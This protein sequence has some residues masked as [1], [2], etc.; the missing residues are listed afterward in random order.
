LALQIHRKEVF[1]FL[2]FFKSPCSDKKT[3][4][5]SEEP[6][7]KSVGEVE[8]GALDLGVR[9]PGLRFFPHNMQTFMR[10]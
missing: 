3:Q 10:T 9:A 8:N 4:G 7:L 1:L 2:G 6:V 5:R